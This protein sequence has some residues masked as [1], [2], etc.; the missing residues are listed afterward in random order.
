M[1][2]QPKNPKTLKAPYEVVTAQERLNALCDTWI[3]EPALGIDTEF[4]RDVTYRATLCLVQIADKSGTYLI[5]PLQEGLSLAP[6]TAVL[7]NPKC[8]KVFHSG[9]Q[10]LEMF[11]QELGILPAPVFDTQVA[12]MLCSFGDHIGYVTLVE[13][14]YHEQIDKSQRLTNWEQRPL[15]PQQLAYA[16]QD[17]TF[18]LR[19]H[20]KLQEMLRRKQRQNWMNEEMA[21]LVNPKLY[22]PNYLKQLEKLGISSQK[23]DAMVRALL[24]LETRET[25]AQEQNKPRQFIIPDDLLRSIALENPKDAT[26]L[27][28]I[29]QS[30][31]YLEAPALRDRVLSQLQDGSSRL[32]DD[33][34]YTQIEPILEP[35]KPDSL[36]VDCL[37]VLLKEVAKEFH[38]TE[39]CIITIRELHLMAVLRDKARTQAHKGWRYHIFGE[40]ALAFLRGELALSCREGRFHKLKPATTENKQ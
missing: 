11:I 13:R 23:P 21:A 31:R 37:K 19:L 34:L 3:N 38:L 12:A 2:L 24:L 14:L 26:S 25:I 17:V 9:R 35:S 39:Q 30:K 8:V 5:D 1:T 16:A 15:T 4:M 32:P 40:E 22:Q 20:Q 10:D 6:L 29:R 28:S 7:Q 36:L 33:P 27:F 18:L